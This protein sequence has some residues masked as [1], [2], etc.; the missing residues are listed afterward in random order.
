MQRVPATSPR[1]H[2][3]V[4]SCLWVVLAGCGERGGDGTASGQEPAAR[5]AAPPVRA[6]APDA[7]AYVTAGGDELRLIQ[8]DGSG[9]RAVWR[10]PDTLYSITG[11]AW[12]PDGGEIAFASDH[13]MAVSLYQRD[14]YAVAPDGGG[15]RRV[16]NPPAHAELASLRKGTVTVT[17]QSATMETGPFFVY[18]MGAPEPQQV[19]L[20]IGSTQRLTFTDVAD[21]GDGVAQPVVAISGINRWWDAAAA[22]DVQ[23]GRTVA[24]GTLT[25]SGAIEHFGADAPFWRADGSSVGFFLGPT[26][27]LSR[28]PSAPPPGPSYDELLGAEVFGPVC[29]ADWGPAPAADE[30][31]LADAREYTA[32]GTTHVLRVKEGSRERGAPVASFGRY[33]RITD[34]RWLPDASGFVVARQDDLLDEDINLYRFD[35]ATGELRRLTDFT[36]EFVRRFSLSPDGRAVAFERVRGGSIHDIATLPSEVWVMNLDGSGLRMLAQDGAFPAW[37][38]ARR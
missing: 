24:A 11:P 38:P 16:T 20:T 9:G 33:V 3:L 15:L 5:R 28:V 22:A 25:L 1:V 34:L 21:L 7:V 2:V 13:E 36:G 17:V 18:V 10:V 23:P 8:P 27:L 6:T 30:L 37:N 32:S 14:V 4:L 29:T 31:L 26:C 35:F 12:R 19:T